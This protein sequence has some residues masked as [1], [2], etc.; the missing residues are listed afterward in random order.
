MPNLIFKVV[1]KMRLSFNLKAQ[2]LK[3][4]PLI[5]DKFSDLTNFFLPVLIFKKRALNQCIK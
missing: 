4:F 5:S 3:S 2:S 1:L